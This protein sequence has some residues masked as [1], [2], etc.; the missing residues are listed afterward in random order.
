MAQL[1]SLDCVSDN[2]PLPITQERFYDLCERF[3]DKKALRAINN[4]SLVPKKNEAPS[5]YAFIDKWNGFEIALR[6]ALASIRA[7]KMKKAF[8]V[9]QITLPS[10]L[11]QAA[12]TATELDNPLQAEQFMC[13]YRLDFLETLRPTDAFS[14][15]AV[16][17]YALKLKL[18]SRMSLFDGDEGQKAYQNIYNAIVNGDKEEIE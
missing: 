12:R 7:E 6:F 1:P 15:D 16:F 11:L 9:E 4:L 10:H 2:S 3:L 13:K 5:G 18:L 17:Y 14:I 8:D